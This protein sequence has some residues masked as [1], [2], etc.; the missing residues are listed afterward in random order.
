M[1]LIQVDLSTHIAY[2]NT[3]I[4]YVSIEYICI[5]YIYIGFSV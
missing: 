5:L 1:I 3:C 2:M 4:L